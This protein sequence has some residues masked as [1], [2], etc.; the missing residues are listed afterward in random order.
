M[1]TAA[2]WVC[3]ALMVPAVVMAQ[4]VKSADAWYT[5]GEN[6]YNLGEF[7]KAVDA[8]KKGFE[9]E[10]V[11]S[12][13]AAYLYNIAQSYRQAKECGNAQFFYKRYL[14]LKDNDTKKPLRPEKR[15]EIEELIKQ[16]DDCAKQQEALTKKPPD[17]NLKPGGE[18][19]T[20]TGPGT[21]P[22]NPQVG[23]AGG[24]GEDG[25]DEDGGE[26]TKAAE[27]SGP[28]VLSARVTGGASKIMTGDP[29]VPVPVQATFALVG[30]YPLALGEQ[31]TLELGAAFSLTPV[32]FTDAM[33]GSQSAMLIGALANAGA[34][35]AVT[36]KIGIR[37]DLGLGVLAFTG[38]SESPFTDFAATTGALTM[39][40]LRVGASVDFA[41][42]PNL[43]ATVT[44]LAFSY[45]PAKTGLKEGIS[46]LSSL[47]FMVGLGYR[48]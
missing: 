46:A 13:K 15:T 25:E 24:A 5:E 18:T 45:S 20:Q 2:S 42:T 1:R 43:V 10:T 19:N 17:S 8:F 6:H 21:T 41:L 12:K 11:E 38:A 28:S 40:R 30:G 7:T 4:P 44:P 23:D 34:T 33:G 3:A 31:L 26:V 39:F 29:D 48:M 22:P 27:V 36:P 35:F 37:G 9:A 32:P 16:L 14:A 47:D